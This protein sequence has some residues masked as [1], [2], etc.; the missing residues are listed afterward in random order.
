M[1]H[2]TDDS[3]PGQ[4]QQLEMCFSLRPWH[5]ARCVRDVGWMRDVQISAQTLIVSLGLDE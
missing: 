1:K 5:L 4:P 3:Q 2:S